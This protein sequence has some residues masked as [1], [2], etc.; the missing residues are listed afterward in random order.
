MIISTKEKKAETATALVEE[1]TAE[2]LAF[3][4]PETARTYRSAADQ[5]L[6]LTDSDDN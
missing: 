4:S 2:L 1:W 5:F 3:R 6:A